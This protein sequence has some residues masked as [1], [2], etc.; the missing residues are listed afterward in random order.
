MS[1]VPAPLAAYPFVHWEEVHFRDLDLLGHANNVVYASWCESARVAYYLDLMQVPLEQMGL[2][3]AEITISYKA[4]AFF[5][6]RLAL[7]VRVST[8]GT[9]S[10]VLE[11]VFVRASDEVLIA[12]SSNVL[13]AYDYQSGRTVPV[14]DE[15]R[16]RVA[17][18][19]EQHRPS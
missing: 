6:D 17:A 5:G 14:S 1:Q 18:Q 16:Q 10:F 12:T 19:A 3:L 11:V 2:I 8:I 7:G 15:F 4:P 13:V 9:R